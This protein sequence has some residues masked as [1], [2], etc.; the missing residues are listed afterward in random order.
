MWNWIKITQGFDFIYCRRTTKLSFSHFNILMDTDT[1][2]WPRS[3]WLLTFPCILCVSVCI[4]LYTLLVHV[5][6]QVST[7]CQDTRLLHLKGPVGPP[8]HSYS[9]P[10][11]P[12]PPLTLATTNVSSVCALL[13]VQECCMNGINSVKSFEVSFLLSIIPLR[14]IHVVAC[15]SLFL[16]C[17]SLF[18]SVD[19]SHRNEIFM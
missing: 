7:T 14:S 15:R 6:I 1:T 11:S 4:W 3:F 12:N 19:V 16:Y 13:L 9:H 17:W 5:R 18:H 8:F 2:L 10:F